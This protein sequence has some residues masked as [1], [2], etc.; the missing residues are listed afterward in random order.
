MGSAIGGLLASAGND[1][2]LVDVWREAVAAINRD[3]LKV[4]NRAGNIATHNVHAVNSPAEIGSPV[5]LVL[6]FVKCYHTVDA[7][8]S[9]AEFHRHAA[10]GAQWSE[11]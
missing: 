11:W 1:V 6:V 4:Q 9:A 7:V 10:G 2:T 3:G 5:E 8:K